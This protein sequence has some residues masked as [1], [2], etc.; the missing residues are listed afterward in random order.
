MLRKT[1]LVLAIASALAACS[2]DAKEQAKPGAE[3]AAQGG[4]TKDGK[5]APS[6]T[7][8]PEDVLTVQS[9]SIA[10]GPVVTGSVR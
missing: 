4:A 8:A 10:S 7:V 1:I 3:V 2:K 9:N 6:L 5:P